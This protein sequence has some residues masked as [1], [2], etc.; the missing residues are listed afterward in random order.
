[1]KTKEEIEQLAELNINCE[2]MS[3]KWEMFRK[4]YIKAYEDISNS[5][6]KG[7]ECKDSIGQTWCCNQ[8]GLPYDTR[9]SKRYTEEDIRNTRL[10]K[11]KEEIRTKWIRHTPLLKLDDCV[12]NA[13]EEYA[14][15]CQEDMA[16]KKYTEEDIKKAFKFYAYAHIS[17][18]PHSYE[19]LEQDYLQFINSLN[20]QDTAFNSNFLNKK[21]NEVR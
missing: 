19:K 3:P 11:T 21:D 4:G 16:D 10:M 8:C 13:M 1:M 7:C 12:D 14:T 17:Q 9:K 18:Q 15:Q 5:W 20:K 2:F 6:T